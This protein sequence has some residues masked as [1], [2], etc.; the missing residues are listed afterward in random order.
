MP[1]RIGEFQVLGELGKGANSTILHI[2]R[3]SD[4]KQYALKIV[5]IESEEDH[6]Y[7]EQAEHE[8]RIAQKLNHRNL[9][10]IYIL[11]KVPKWLFF[12][13]KEVRLLI[14]YVPGKTLDKQR[15][16]SFPKL[17]QVFEQVASGLAHMH[18]RD[19]YHA[20][21]KP[22]NIMLSRAG[23]VKIIDY[24]LAWTK[25][26]PKN[27][28]QGTPEYMAPEQVKERIVN[29][30]TD[31]FNFGATMYRLCTWK[32]IPKVMDEEGQVVPHQIWERQLQGVREA[33]P[34]CPAP[35]AELIHRC[36]AYKPQ[37]R[38]ESMTDVHETL[39]AL[40]DQLVTDPADR[41][42]ALEWSDEASP[43]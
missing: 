33:N 17:V 19:I 24:G 30:Q 36:L 11:E 8:F 18:R 2:R 16:L 22:G 14:E 4:S 5:P 34:A 1:E 43:S 42:E 7:L 40:V 9:I 38:P 35:L 39:Q 15:I 20:D 29:E 31:I 28:V 12:G 25:D 13:V 37:K 3:S 26:A 41:L 27:R 32:N 23:V 10:R 6:K 21:L